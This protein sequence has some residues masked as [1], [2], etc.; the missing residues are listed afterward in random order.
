[1][2]L[3]SI[4]LFLSILLISSGSQDI[5]AS[6]QDKPLKCEVDPYWTNLFNRTSG[7]I[8][9]DGIFSIPLN[10]VDAIGSANSNTKTYWNFSDTL[11]GQVNTSNLTFSS[12]TMVNHSAAMLT[13]NTPD[14]SRMN[15][16]YGYKGDMSHSNL[17]GYKTWL[18]DGIAI[19]NYL[20]LFA[21]VPEPDWSAQQVDIIRIPLVNGNPNY[22]NMVKYPNVPLYYEDS[23]HELVFG[24]GILDNSTA[25]GVPSGDGYV[26][27]YGYRNNKSTQTKQL[28]VARVPR[29]QFGNMSSWKFYHNGQW[30]DSL[31]YTNNNQ[32]TLADRI[33][34]EF[35]VTYINSG[36]YAGK[37][38]LVYTRDVMSTVLEY[39]IGDSPIG[40][41]GPAVP[42][43]VCP[44]PDIYKN[45]TY[46]YNA[47]AH[48]H[49]SAPGEL[50]I[51][52]N[53]NRL[54]QFPSTNEIY[55]PRFVKLKLNELAPDPV[56]RPPQ[57]N[58]ALGKPATASH[59]DFQAPRAV[60]G[61][62][63]DINNHKWC[64]ISSGDMWLRV[65]LGSP[66]TITR[67]VVRHASVA[68]EPTA[69]ITR[70]FKLQ[71]SNDGVTWYD[72]D[73]VTYNTLPVTDRDVS[74]FTARYVRLY[75][76]KP[77]QTGCTDIAARIYEFEVYENN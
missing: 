22:N 46:T 12:L 11:I 40:P 30:K 28:I 3:L 15:F 1:M 53:V 20:Y 44:E 2:L 63:S 45:D 76:T 55:R 23:G 5:I 4:T 51:S 6:A 69:W 24:G 48:P 39:R 72:V 74:P 18:Q 64:G 31:L 36:I 59:S 38:M 68:G 43:Y 77:T 66:K 50:L 26:Y 10:G 52:Y 62:W 7:W 73:S 32:A 9:G 70:D 14:P 33:S 17:Y 71:R 65:D 19:G 41:F 61:K 29:N 49:L 21:M 67:W 13:G 34:T 60:D 35:S 27:V 16:V 8:G 37:Y 58:V 25:A 56:V 54:G 75:V 42:F 47:K 57:T